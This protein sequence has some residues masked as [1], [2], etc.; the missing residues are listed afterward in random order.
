MIHWEQPGYV[1]SFTTRTGG[2]SEGPYE[3][4]N[5][6]VSTGDDPARVERNRAI[7]CERLG[8][9]VEALAFNRQVHS[10]T[11]HRAQRGRRGEPG[12]GLWSD[13]PGQPMLA[14]AADCLPIA[15]VRRTGARAL[16][17][18]HAGWRGLSE[19]VVEAG[20]RALGGGDLAAVVGPA[21]GACCYEVGPEVHAALAARDD[22]APSVRAPH[23][24]VA[25]S[26]HAPRG[27]ATPGASRTIDLRAIARE[28]L[29][30]AGVARVL[31]V[32]AC[33]ICDERFFSH[34]REGARAGR[35]AGVAW[36]S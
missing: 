15:I 20:A 26:A 1:V 27:T 13:E 32:E 8:L 29:L 18:L 4:L 10:P 19:G 31:D 22:G 17:V 6:V 30:S 14:F 28:R 23:D 11:V 25:P 35:Q 34:R 7:V 12:D 16:A 5:L 9:D 21:I 36:L 3:S 24:G 2:V 33:T